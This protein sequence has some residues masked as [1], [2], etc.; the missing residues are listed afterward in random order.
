MEQM[1]SQISGF[2]AL[3]GLSI[4]GALVI[5]IVGKLVAGFGRNLIRR[6]LTRTRTDPSVVSFAASLTYF[7]VLTAAVIAALSKVGVQTTSL[8][9]VLGTAGPGRGP[10]PQGFP[11][12]LRGPGSCFWS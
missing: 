1:Y 6:A 12:Q 4:L 10:G 8:L 3:Y 5:L 2:I 9:A 11:E 7:L